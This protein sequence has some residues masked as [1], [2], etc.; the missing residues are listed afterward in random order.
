MS[1]LYLRL[2]SDLTAAIKSK[3]DARSSTLR[4][5]IAAIKNKEIESSEALTDDDIMEVLVREK[6]TR[7]ESIEQYHLGGREDLVQHEQAEITI[8]NSYLPTQMSEDELYRIVESVIDEVGAQDIKDMGKVM[9]M[10]KDRLQ[11]KADM[12]MVSDQVKSALN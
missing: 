3:N 8:I 1:E 5:L 11:G 10:L 12:K 2:R 7:Q 9:G 6:K 4:L